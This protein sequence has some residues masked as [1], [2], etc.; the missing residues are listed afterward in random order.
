MKNGKASYLI[1]EDYQVSE[2]FLESLEEKEEKRI[3][4]AEILEAV[5]KFAESHH[6]A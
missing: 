1:D 3:Q 4:D 2:G 6:R 5:K